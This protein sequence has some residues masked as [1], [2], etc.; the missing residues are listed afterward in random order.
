MSKLDLHLLYRKETGQNRPFG[1]FGSAWDES[2]ITDEQHD[3]IEWLEE[4]V[5]EQ[6]YEINYIPIDGKELMRIL[7][8][9][10]AKRQ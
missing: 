2:A 1:E 7:H 3:Y 10:E 9:Y 5:E 8:N 6:E 4:K